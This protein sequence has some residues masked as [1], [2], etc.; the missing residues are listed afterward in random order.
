MFE[1]AVGRLTPCTRQNAGRFVSE[2]VGEGARVP[3]V[4]SAADVIVVSASERRVRSAHAVGD[5]DSRGRAAG[6]CASR[7]LA[8]IARRTARLPAAAYFDIMI[9]P[10]LV[11]Y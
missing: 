9:G 3:D 6:L 1:S 10:L 7:W 2:T 5:E 11:T 4:T 8:P